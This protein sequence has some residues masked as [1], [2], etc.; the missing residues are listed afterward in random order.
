[1]ASGEA[2]TC[3]NIDMKN[4]HIDISASLPDIARLSRVNLLGAGRSWRADHA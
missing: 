4:L 2:L 3:R 1:M